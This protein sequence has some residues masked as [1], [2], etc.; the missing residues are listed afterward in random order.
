MIVRAETGKVDTIGQQEDAFPR[1]AFIRDEFV[2]D[3][4]RTALDSL[5][6]IREDAS[7]GCEEDP[8]PR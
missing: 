2:C 8:V 7:L 1:H 4:T 3:E 6:G 5:F